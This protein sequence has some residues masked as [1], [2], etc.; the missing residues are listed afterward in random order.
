MSCQFVFLRPLGLRLAYCKG[1]IKL[2]G[3][4]YYVRSNAQL[5]TGKYWITTTNG[6]LPQGMY[7]FGTDGKMINPPDEPKPTEPTTE[8]PSEEPTETT[9]EEPTTE[10]PTTEEPTEKPTEPEKP[11]VK[12]GIYRENGV[13][14]FYEN[15]TRAYCKGLIFYEGYYYYVRSN[16]QLAIG[17]YWVTTHNDLLPSGMYNFDEEGRMIR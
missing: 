12:E 3:Y 8:K 16:A 11:T 17:K 7:N 4:Y 2:D 15:G 5:A 6:L 13:L 1:L 14:Y 9:T 10:E